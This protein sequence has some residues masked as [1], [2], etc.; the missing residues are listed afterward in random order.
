MS[1]SALS[2]Q[3]T[4]STQAQSGPWLRWRGTVW[5]H[6]GSHQVTFTGKQ[7]LCHRNGSHKAA[8]RRQTGY[9]SRSQSITVDTCLC[10]CPSAFPP[11]PPIPQ[12]GERYFGWSWKWMKIYP[13]KKQTG[14]EARKQSNVL[15]AHNWWGR[16]LLPGDNHIGDDLVTILF[17]NRRD[18]C[19]TI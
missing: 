1:P 9:H 3:V 17:L 13:L 4:T 14:D 15:P 18:V 16:A 2:G 5:C 11:P 10:F 12:G 8:A 7:R 19:S 6:F